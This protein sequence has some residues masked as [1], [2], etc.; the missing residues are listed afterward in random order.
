MPDRSQ[1]TLSIEKNLYIVGYAHLDTQW[2]WTYVDTIQN[3]IR[4]TMEQNFALF[5]KYPNYIFNFTGSRRYEL[6]KEYYP[7]DYAKV[8]KL[9]RRWALVARGLIGGRVRCQHSLP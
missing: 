9:C 5:D 4:N 3:D 2:R 1:W 7:E 8:K 6:M